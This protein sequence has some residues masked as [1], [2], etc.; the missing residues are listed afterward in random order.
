MQDRSNLGTAPLMRDR[1]GSVDPEGIMPVR[2]LH[3]AASGGYPMG[4]SVNLMVVAGESSGDRHA[5]RLIA[6]LRSDFPGEA[7]NFFGSAGRKMKEQGVEPVVD[8]ERMAIMGGL[9]IAK[10]LPMFVRAFRKLKKAARAQNPDAAILV[11]FPDFNIR[12]AK[13]LKRQ[14]VPVIY[15]ISPQ[16]W[17]WKQRRVEKIKR[18]V[19]LL[20]SIL[21][22]EKEFYESR[23]FDRV[24]YVGNPT[25][26]DVTPLFDA[27]EFRRRH[28]ISD[29]ERI[30]SLLPGSRSVEFR[31]IV[32]ELTGAASILGA[33]FPDTRFVV[34]LAPAREREEF[35]DAVRKGGGLGASILERLIFV[36]GETYE[37]VAASEAAAVTSGTATLETAVL[38]TPMVVV[39]KLSQLNFRAIRPFVSID[40]FSLV[41]LIA[42]KRLAVEL[43]QGDLNAATLSAELERLMEPEI[44]RQFRDELESVRGVLGSV[45]ASRNAAREVMNLVS[46]NYESSG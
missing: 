33:K 21:P 31:H 18:S 36:K 15:Y 14:G 37:A 35:E 30:V 40:T 4:R 44:N 42:G 41:N 11:D 7:F 16:V 39:Y 32:P 46:S 43:I 24:V 2:A 5:A 38:G 10:E 13:S 8:A 1:F 3:L 27:R 26:E 12:L 22:F 17:A 34:P 20:L 9:E 28:G 25:A 45:D 19:D 6:S 23:G 29:N